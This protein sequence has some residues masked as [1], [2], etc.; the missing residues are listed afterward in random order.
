MVAAM[1]AAGP[2]RARARGTG[3]T[4]PSPRRSPVGSWRPGRTARTSTTRSASRTPSPP[5]LYDVARL[6]ARTRANSYVVAAAVPCLP[7]TSPSSSSRPSGSTWRFGDGDG[8]VVRGDAVEFCLVATQRR[9]RADTSL[10]PDGPGARR[11]ARDRPGV[12]RPRRAW[13][14]ADRSRTVTDRGTRPVRI[15][16]C[17]GFYRRPP[18][19]RARAARRTGP[20][21]RAHRRLP[22]RAHDAHLVEAAPARP[23]AGL[24]ADVRAPDGRRARRLPRPRHPGRRERRRPQPPRAEGAPRGDRRARRPRRRRWPWSRA[25][26]SR[27]ARPTSPPRRGAAQPRHGRAARRAGRRRRDRQRL[28][29]RVRDRRSAR[30]PAPTSSSRAA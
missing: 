21:R 19:R 4:S 23:D 5:A 18:R 2:S 29:R 7:A 17:S 28:P 11:V 27:A 14:R 26:T 3:R 13:P 22:R 8:E 20:L 15:A 16:N 24:R 30:R 25:T 1:L 6:C 9:H 10:E 12:R